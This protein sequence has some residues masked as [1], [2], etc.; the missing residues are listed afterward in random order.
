MKKFR[1]T[2]SLVEDAFMVGDIVESIEELEEGEV[3]KIN[4]T[5]GGDDIYLIGCTDGTFC[6][7]V[8]EFMAVAVFE[9]VGEA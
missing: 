7:M 6:V 1:C 2:H 5:H 3:F 4:R 9:M 8:N